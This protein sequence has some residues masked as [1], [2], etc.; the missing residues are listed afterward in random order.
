MRRQDVPRI[1]DQYPSLN[2]IL[3]G[4]ARDTQ[5]ATH[6]GEMGSTTIFFFVSDSSSSKPWLQV[7]VAVYNAQGMIGLDCNKQEKVACHIQPGHFRPASRCSG[8]KVPQSENSSLPSQMN[9][10]APVVLWWIGGEYIPA[11]SSRAETQYT[12]GHQMLTHNDPKA[13]G[14]FQKIEISEFF[15][16]H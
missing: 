13:L 1:P 8:K 4:L 15:K 7:A 11:P 10:H 5:Q 6:T 16:C 3:Q 14:G 12:H 2:G 9:A